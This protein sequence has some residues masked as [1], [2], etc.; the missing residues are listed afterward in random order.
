M[1]DVLCAFTSAHGRALRTSPDVPFPQGTPGFF[2]SLEPI[3]GAIEAVNELR[4]LYDVYVLTAPSTRNAHS[5]SE[6]RL[7]IEDHFDY[8]FTK[9]LILSPHKGLLK[10]H[11]LVD[12]RTSGKGQE[13]F[14]GMLIEF[15]S[16]SFP[17]WKAVLEFLKQE[18]KS[19]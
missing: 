7:W 17:D 19:R 14:E 4:E 15:G 13:S 3:D 5:Y 9:K 10:G 12:D 8:E 2:H 1:D 16:D 6:K 11:Y 18:T